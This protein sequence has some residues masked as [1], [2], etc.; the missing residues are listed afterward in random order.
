ML[1]NLYILSLVLGAV[2]L[3][4]SLF[5]SDKPVDADDE[6]GAAKD[7]AEPS[8]VGQLDGVGGGNFFGRTVRSRRFWTFFICFFGMTGLVLDGLDLMSAPVTFIVA[9]AVG[10]ISGAGIS[11]AVRIASS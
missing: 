6:A 5:L 3:T 2:L 10:A 4:A 11:A 8:Q 9:V 1:I 7:A